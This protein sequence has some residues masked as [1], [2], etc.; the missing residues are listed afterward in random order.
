MRI[1]DLEERIMKFAQSRRVVKTKDG[2][3]GYIQAVQSES[4]EWTAYTTGA[5]FAA[6]PHGRTFSTQ[7]AAEEAAKQ[8]LE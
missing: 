1:H 2:K 7:Q 6:S 8:A 5:A 4:G 3:I